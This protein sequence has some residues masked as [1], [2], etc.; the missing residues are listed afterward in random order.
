MKKIIFALFIVLIS[1]SNINIAN[2]GEIDSSIKLLH[3]I[4]EDDYKDE[5]YVKS[6]VFRKVRL[7]KMEKV[8]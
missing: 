7:K 4:S 1:C 2:K 6:N 5:A 3:D 8:Q